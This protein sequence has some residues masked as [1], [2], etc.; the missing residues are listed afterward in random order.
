MSQSVRPREY[1]RTNTDTSG[2]QLNINTLADTSHRRQHICIYGNCYRIHTHADAHADRGE[3]MRAACEIM[4]SPPC[5][6][7]RKGR[8]RPTDRSIRHL[9]FDRRST[10]LSPTATGQC[11]HVRCRLML[12]NVR[13]LIAICSQTLRANYHD[14]HVEQIL[15]R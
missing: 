14:L 3:I 15:I 4:L 9:G 2:V 1:M 10:Q 12:R 5:A 13:H 6:P 11:M 7:A 8:M